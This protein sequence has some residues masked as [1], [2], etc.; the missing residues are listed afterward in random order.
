MQ[1]T[2]IALQREIA[3]TRGNDLKT[4]VGDLIAELAFTFQF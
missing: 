2:V 1:Y 3:A 4:L